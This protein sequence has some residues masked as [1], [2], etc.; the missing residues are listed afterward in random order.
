MSP[1]SRS[2]GTADR[3]FRIVL[4]VICVSIVA[5]LV[6]AGGVLLYLR[7]TGEPVTPDLY[8]GGLKIGI[9]SALVAFALWQSLRRRH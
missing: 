7:L 9:P 2:Q 6:M 1:Q 5:F 3:I 8:A 4:M